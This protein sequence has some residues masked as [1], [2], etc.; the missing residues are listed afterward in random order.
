MKKI[1]ITFAGLALAGAAVAQVNPTRPMLTGHGNAAIQ[2][3]K[4]MVTNQTDPK[5]EESIKLEKFIVTG[6]LLG[7]NPTRP[8]LTG[9]GNVT[10]RP[11]RVI[12][13][14]QTDPQAEEAVKLEKFVVTGSLL[15]KEALRR[16]C[17]R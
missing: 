17:D 13:T 4:I 11:G 10:I 14:N 3:A 6:S 16:T 7:V 9:H 12:V 5:G 15:T 8:M 2:P 1:L